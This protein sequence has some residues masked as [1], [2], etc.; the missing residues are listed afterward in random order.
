MRQGGTE[1][2]PRWMELPFLGS[3]TVGDY[4]WR[5]GIFV[6]ETERMGLL[7]ARDV[8]KLCKLDLASF[9]TLSCISQSM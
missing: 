2:G 4:I 1:K 9:I 5:E 7:N 3:T 6:S 8:M